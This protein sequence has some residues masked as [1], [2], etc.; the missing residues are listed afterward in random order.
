MKGKVRKS[1]QMGENMED[2]QLISTR[3]RIVRGRY[4]LLPPEGLVTN[5]LPEMPECDVRVLAS[6][7]LGADF[8][9][10]IVTAKKGQGTVRKFAGQ[11]GMEA[12]LYVLE[13]DGKVIFE[14]ERYQLQKD[15]FFYS[16]PGKGFE[17]INDGN[18]DLKVLIQTHHYIYAEGISEPDM[19]FGNAYRD[20]DVLL[21]GRDRNPCRELFPYD[22]RYDWQIV[23]N[24]FE[25]G[26]SHEF[27]ETHLQ[28]HALY[29]LEGKANYMLN[30][31][32][33]LI[34][35]GDFLWV[36]PYVPH[37]CYCL[38]TESFIYLFSKVVN[39]TPM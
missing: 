12:F 39:R 14:G 8:V 28:E 32:W 6:R 21:G 27:I 13:G 3:A 38:G 23:V 29:C 7:E 37:G 17:F 35:K 20:E 33:T 9:Q 1:A 2:I 5:L 30:D 31:Q 36:G 4:A 25:S 15:S 19:L 22:L 10:L 16:P 11:K 26:T 34:Q 18:D 24:I